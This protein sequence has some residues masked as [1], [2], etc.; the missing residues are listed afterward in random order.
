M[1]ADQILEQDPLFLDTETTGLYRSSEVVEVAV[2]DAQGRE[3]F[4]SLV[5]PTRGI[6]AEATAVHGI[7]DEMVAK[8]PSWG[9]VW[10]HLR[11][12]LGGRAV[13]I[14]NAPFDLRMMRQS[15]EKQKMTWAPIGAEV[16]C[17]M[18]MYRRFYPSLGK[19]KA[20]KYSLATAC[21]EFGIDEE[22]THG[23]LADA[24]LTAK[25]FGYLARDGKPAVERP[26]AIERPAVVQRAAASEP[27]PPSGGETMAHL[28]AN[29]NV[30]L[31]T[32]LLAAAERLNAR[33]PAHVLRV[34]ALMDQLAK[35]GDVD[36]TL[37]R[38]EETVFGGVS[39]SEEIEQLGKSIGL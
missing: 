36:A 28:N 26:A 3:L 31:L 7:T 37:A 27:T 18:Q 39:E 10:P 20:R 17:V 8:A 19:G 34:A 38:L 5:R 16:C 13:G 23:A 29:L 35:A 14:Y 24:K 9:S 4:D 25:V 2:V 6:P 1:R 30:S 33:S 11:E 32:V 22:Q 12:L 21:R 15:V